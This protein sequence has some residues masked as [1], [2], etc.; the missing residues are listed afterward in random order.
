[1]AKPDPPIVIIF[2]RLL[3]SLANPLT[4]SAKSQKYLNVCSWVKSSRSSNGI[5]STVLVG[6]NPKSGGGATMSLGLS[7]EQLHQSKKL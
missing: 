6:T 5:T 1:M 3:S 2:G 7:Q 4:G